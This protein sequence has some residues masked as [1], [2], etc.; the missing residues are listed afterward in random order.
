MATVMVNLSTGAVSTHAS[1]SHYASF[2]NLTQ[3]TNYQFRVRL[4]C[5]NSGTYG[6][7][8]PYNNFTTSSCKT[9]TDVV[10][11]RNFPNPFSDYTTIEFNLF[12]DS[13]V[14]IKVYDLTGKQVAT[15]LDNETKAAGL[16]QVTFGGDAYPSGMYM[17]TI[18]AGEYVTTRK[19]NLVK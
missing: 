14:T 17:Y 19:M 3:S 16:H 13:P 1:T 18:Q 12:N 15:L 7:W 5:G 11:F 6:G 2:S 8:S 10:Q 9:D 4:E